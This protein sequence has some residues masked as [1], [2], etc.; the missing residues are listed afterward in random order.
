MEVTAWESWE[1][2]A[3]LAVGTVQAPGAHRR[4][5]QGIVLLGLHDPSGTVLQWCGADTGLLVLPG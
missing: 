3:G 1:L 2:R 5:R 4:S